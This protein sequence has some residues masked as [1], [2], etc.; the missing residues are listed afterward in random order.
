MAKPEKI[1]LEITPEAKRLLGTLNEQ[2]LFG[3]TLADV[4]ERLLMEKLRE[5]VREG[6]VGTVGYPDGRT[7]ALVRPA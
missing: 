1:T 3:V 6:W 7:Q 2:G 4:A 5:V